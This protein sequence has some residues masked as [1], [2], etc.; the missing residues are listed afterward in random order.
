MM[1]NWRTLM[2]AGGLLSL[3]G[4][5]SPERAPD[6]HPL[7]QKVA[8][9]LSTTK[10]TSTGRR[11]VPTSY[12]LDIVLQGPGQVRVEPSTLLC[13][14]T[15]R[16]NV[17]NK[18]SKMKLVA[19]EGAAAKFVGWA[20]ACTSTTNTCEVTVSS[21]LSVTAKFIDA[22][23]VNILNYG[24]VAS[25][26]TNNQ[27]AIQNAINDAA[28]KGVN[29]FV[30]AGAFGYSGVLN[31]NGPVKLYGLGDSSVL[32]ALDPR[33]ETI[34]IRGKG[35]SVQL[36]KLTQAPN[37]VT[38]QDPF[39]AQRITVFNATDWTIDQ[40]NI[41]SSAAAGIMMA[42]SSNG[43]ISNSKVSN[44]LADS[45]H[46]TG[47]SSF[48]TI[49]KN[50]VNNSG[51]DGIAVVSYGH[52]ALSH[53]VVATGNKITNNKWG[54]G[55]T[56]VGGS[57]V[58]Y[59]NNFVSNVPQWSCFLIAQEGAYNTHPGSNIVI[60]NNTVENC[61][62]TG[63]HAGIFL[64]GDNK[65]NTNITVQ[66]NLVLQ[67]GSK[68]TISVVGQNSNVVLENNKVQGV[69]VYVQT[70]SQVT[71]NVAWTSGTVGMQ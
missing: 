40:V 29:V 25:A 51:D 60:K 62:G 28:K 45:I 44:T 7:L 38:R 61:G 16:V 71:K 14:Q 59:E 64:I 41:D 26:T 57:N 4:F 43:V 20:G 19:R 37:T 13:T 23:D 32:N 70:P 18:N 66:N 63:G 22:K 31:V 17:Y 12:A 3:A 9:S 47:G 36:L 55:M 15:C 1:I 6:T 48:I 2:L 52:D 65:P 10:T 35:A 39:E 49:T 42:G 50:V 27:T 46:V 58:R 11:V 8:V 24:A 69:A 33:N 5:T 54:R 53:D 21:S 68:P 56:V 30:P 34:F 67:T